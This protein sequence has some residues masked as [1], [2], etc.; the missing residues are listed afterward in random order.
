MIQHVFS[1]IQFVSIKH[2][3]YSVS[4]KLDPR[5]P[6]EAYALLTTKVSK[7][8]VKLLGLLK[9]DMPAALAVC[10]AERLFGNGFV[11]HR[12]LQ[13]LED[14]IANGKVFGMVDEHYNLL[15]VAAIQKIDDETK[16]GRGDPCAICPLENQIYFKMM[17][18][19]PTQRG[20]GLAKP[21][22][23]KRVIEALM[24]ENMEYCVMKSNNP[25]V[26]SAYSGEYGF[27]WTQYGEDYR[28]SDD[29][30][31]GHAATPEEYRISKTFVI[32]RHELLDW[33]E[34]EDPKAF[35]NLP[36]YARKAH[37]PAAPRIHYA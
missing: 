1:P 19:H 31:G 37:D 28:L 36:D 26:Q 30:L 22:Y 12:T 9:A 33:L 14:M 20:Q 16:A 15:A 27:G 18:T 11:A 6:R 5:T 2:V 32:S 25:D 17:V 21:L 4:P 29:E 13:D 23:K 8:S 10:E 24:Q 7:Q 35:A 3:D 34:R